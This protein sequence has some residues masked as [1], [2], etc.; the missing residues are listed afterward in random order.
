MTTSCEHLK[1]KC[2]NC[3]ETHSANSRTCEVLIAIKARSAT[4]SISA[5]LTVLFSQTSTTTHDWE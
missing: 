4:T 5:E 3:R 2:S 1:S